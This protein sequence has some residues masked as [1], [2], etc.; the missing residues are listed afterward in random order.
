MRA[1]RGSP[2]RRGVV[3]W[4]ILAGALGLPVMVAAFAWEWFQQTFGPLGACLVVIV[5]T[6]V[7]LGASWWLR[8][9]LDTVSSPI[10]LVDT[11]IH[12]LLKIRRMRRLLPLVTHALVRAFGAAH[13]TL[14]LEE[15]QT[16]TYHLAATHGP[17]KPPAVQQLDP[18]SLVILWLLEHRRPL[19]ASECPSG[20]DPQQPKHATDG[21]KTQASPQ[22]RLGWVLENLN[23]DLVV[24]IFRS[25]RLVGFVVVGPKANGR[26]YSAAEVA[27]LS[28]LAGS[29]ALALDNTRRLEE[30]EIAAGKLGSTRTLLLEQQRLADAGK[31]AM[32][33]A[34]EIRNPLT[35][36]KTFTE[37]LE[38]KYEDPEFRKEFVRVIPAEVARIT[39][40]VQ[41]LSDFA[42]P[43]LLKLQPVDVQQVLVDTVSLLSNECLKRDVHVTKQLDSQPIYL[44]ADPAALKQAFLNLCLNALDAMDKGGTL[45]VSS[46]LEETVAVVR[47]SDTGSGIQP[48]HLVALFDPFFSTKA[49][50]MGLGLAVVKQIVN[51]HLGTITVESNVGFGTTFEIRLP[52]VVRLKSTQGIQPPGYSGISSEPYRLPVPIRVLV[53]DDEPKI[54]EFLRERFEH[55]GARVRTAPSGEQALEVLAQEPQELAVLDLK[56]P[57]VDGF[58]VLKRIKAQYPT[59]AVA[60]ITGM[61]DD[62]IDA[63]V[64]SLGALAC[65]HKPLDI[66][67]LQEVAYQVAARSCPPTTV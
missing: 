31:L 29:L 48:E 26:P 36:I 25:R 41:S 30:L 49:S 40:I 38:E 59:T 47:I 55:L 35:G 9:R 67:R 65:I 16:K 8:K 2:G 45:S 23:A 34:H 5:I 56:L 60:V 53:V 46:C 1:A 12:H 14:F 64:R 21:K 42:K 33:L 4:L 27:V 24:P 43:P 20:P 13:A 51:Q 18:S 44:T 61:Y 28:Q 57:N 22:R 3:P 63:Y 15:S 19:R 58:D 62:Q 54:L 39:R 11:T 37:F 17:G 7:T 50:G 10:R 6:Q 52:H 66:P 32:G